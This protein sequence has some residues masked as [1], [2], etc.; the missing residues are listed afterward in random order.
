MPSLSL[1]LF[2]AFPV[3]LILLPRWIEP[4]SLV[5]PVTLNGPPRDGARQTRWFNMGWWEETESFPVAAEALAKKLLTFAQDGG[6]AGGGSV[7]DIGHGSGESLLLHLSSPS[8]PASLYGL[9]SL[10]LHT[11]QAQAL[12]SAHER[13]TG[14]TDIQLFTTSAEF[15]SGRS[16]DQGHP[17]NPM[18]GFLGETSHHGSRLVHN[19]DEDD[20]EDEDGYEHV[21]DTN[22]EKDEQSPVRQPGATRYDLIYILDSIYHYPPSVPAF[23]ST[24]LPVLAP[25]GVV[26]YTDIVPPAS[27]STWKSALISH[28]MGV[29]LANLNVRPASLGAY[30]QQVKELGFAHVEVEDWSDKVWPGFSENLQGRGVFWGLVAR[31]IRAADRSGWKFIAIR[32]VKS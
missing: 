10:P 25:G 28:I 21:R 4:Y 26:A 14:S 8:P 32:A 1:L 2:A 30:K 27:Y 22:D 15:R 23:L 9:T 3:V 12:L 6:Y 11:S 24:L 20:E 5:D 19:G 17:L 7:L 13:L 18:R 29:P 31:A 16:S